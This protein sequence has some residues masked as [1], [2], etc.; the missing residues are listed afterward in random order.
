MEA[1]GRIGDVQEYYAGRGAFSGFSRRERAAASVPNSGALAPRAGCS[2]GWNEAKQ[3]LRI[4]CVLPAVPA[5]QPCTGTSRP[6][7][8]AA[9]TMPA[10]APALRPAKIASPITATGEVALTPQ[11]LRRGRGLRG[12]QAGEPGQ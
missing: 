3:T 5:V 6:G 1:A 11:V 10:A 9:R 4:S 12:E 2:G 8:R 7:W